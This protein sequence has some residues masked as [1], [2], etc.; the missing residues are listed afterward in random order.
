MTVHQDVH[1]A[2]LGAASGPTALLA[3]AE[4][5]RSGMKNLLD[6]VVHELRSPLTVASGYVRLLRDGTVEPD[7]HARTHALQMVED[8]LAECRRLVDELS[9][10]ERLESGA[11]K[12]D[13]R[14]VDLGALAR[15]AA[16]R[17]EA[18]AQLLGAHVTAQTPPDE[19][20]ASADATRVDRI[21]NNLV[22][23]ALDHG[24]ERAE[25]TITAADDGVP[26][27]SVTDSGAGVPPADRER[28]FGRFV[29]GQRSHG[30][31]LGLYLSRQLAEASGGSLDLDTEHE[32]PGA[33]FV[34]R[35]PASAGSG[36]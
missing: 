12:P 14:E 11:L 27:L 34:L 22:A 15:D 8:K 23:N 32:G 28:I 29:R 1:S 7:P 3:D 18:R 31:G 2:G 35:L 20:R 16:S 26:L 33:R 24:G 30:S 9:L 5:A 4:R 21:L 10:A 25:V 36:G 17:A 6:T 13:T 19:V